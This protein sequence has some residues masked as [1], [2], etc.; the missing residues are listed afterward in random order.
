MMKG[1]HRYW[2]SLMEN[3]VLEGI[4]LNLFGG[5]MRDCMARLRMERR[6]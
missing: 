4:R 2:K 6:E 1:L 5:S 3:G